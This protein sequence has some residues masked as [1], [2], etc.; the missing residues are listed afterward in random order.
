MPS[1]G[2]NSEPNQRSNGTIKS[3][4]SSDSRKT[5]AISYVA[6]PLQAHSAIGVG[7]PISDAHL[8]CNRY[9]RIAHPLPNTL[10]I[11]K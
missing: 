1:E 3:N 8:S 2:R 9:H 4:S 7:S 6:E 5:G 11:P 10:P